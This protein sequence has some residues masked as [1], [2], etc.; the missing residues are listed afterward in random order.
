MI[1]IMHTLKV[2]IPMYGSK[3]AEPYPTLV[4]SDDGGVTTKVVNTKVIMPGELYFTFKRQRYYV[5]RFGELIR[6]QFEIVG[7]WSWVKAVLNTAGFEY[8][9]EYDDAIGVFKYKAAPIKYTKIKNNVNKIGMFEIDGKV[10]NFYNW[11]ISTLSDLRR[12]GYELG[13]GNF[14]G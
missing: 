7:T 3:R 9:E 13:G 1:Q 2:T 6:S 14:V 11:Y 8:S 10:A 12:A 5:E 4:V